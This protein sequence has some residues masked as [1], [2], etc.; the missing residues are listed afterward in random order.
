MHNPNSSCFS[1][2]QLFF[3]EFLNKKNS[4]SFKKQK[5]NEFFIFLTKDKKNKNGDIFND[6]NINSD[7]VDGNFP[8][9]KSCF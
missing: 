4:S 3:V 8:L 6:K 1:V 5:K 7:E 9:E 2:L